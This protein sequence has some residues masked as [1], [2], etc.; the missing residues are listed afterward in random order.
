MELREKSLKRPTLSRRCQTIG[1]ERLQ[2]LRSLAV[3]YTLI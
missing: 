1:P 3:C 2:P